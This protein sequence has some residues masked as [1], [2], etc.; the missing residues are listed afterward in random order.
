MGQGLFFVKPGGSGKLRYLLLGK[1]NVNIL[2][3]T[4]HFSKG[5]I[6]S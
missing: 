4:S 3:A 5:G 6:T 2:R 1:R